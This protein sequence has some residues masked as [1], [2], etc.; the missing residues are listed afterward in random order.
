[1]YEVRDV[2][3]GEKKGSSRRKYMKK[4]NYGAVNQVSER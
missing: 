1:M 2:K 3:V 4:R